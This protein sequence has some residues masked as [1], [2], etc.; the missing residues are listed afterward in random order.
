MVCA[1]CWMSGGSSCPELSFK[2][3]DNP[4]DDYNTYPTLFYLGGMP[5]SSILKLHGHIISIDGL[6]GTCNYRTNGHLR[7]VD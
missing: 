1:Y 6:Y 5:T 4:Y 7:L 3:I 2:S